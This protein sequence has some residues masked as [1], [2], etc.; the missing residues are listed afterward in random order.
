MLLCRA[1]VLPCCRAAAGLSSTSLFLTLMLRQCCRARR[2]SSR[3]C[4]ASWCSPS[5][6]PCSSSS[7]SHSGLRPPAASLSGALRIPETALRSQVSPR[8]CLARDA[9]PHVAACCSL[10]QPVAAWCT[11]GHVCLP[12]AMSRAAMQQPGSWPRA[13]PRAVY[14]P[15][16]WKSVGSRCQ[17]SGCDG[18]CRCR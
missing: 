10:L 15:C 12:Q 9:E 1:A 11:A 13:V 17:P 7:A 4:S 18:W 6:P 2:S 5:P 14:G 3:S 8:N 16:L